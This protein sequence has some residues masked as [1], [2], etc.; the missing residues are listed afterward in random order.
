M[1]TEEVKNASPEVSAG[2]EN[3][4]NSPPAIYTLGQLNQRTAQVIGQ[5]EENGPALITRHGHFVA[6]ISPIK[7]E[8][9][10]RVLAEI[11]RELGKQA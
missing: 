4:A 3:S 2:P 1:P 8:I 10:S 5:I 6:M 9:E 11:A 7:G